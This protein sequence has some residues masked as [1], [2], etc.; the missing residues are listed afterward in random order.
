MQCSSFTYLEQYLVVEEC[1][2]EGYFGIPE[3]KSF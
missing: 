1:S 2:D 3:Y